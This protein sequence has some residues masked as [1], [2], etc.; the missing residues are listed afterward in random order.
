MDGLQNTERQLR[1]EIEAVRRELF[2]LKGDLSNMARELNQKMVDAE[3]EVDQV[4]QAVDGI[5]G[6]TGIHVSREGRG[7][8]ISGEEGDSMPFAVTRFM[9]DTTLKASIVPGRI[10]LPSRDGS[11]HATLTPVV[12][13]SSAVD[14]WSSDDD[15]AVTDRYL[16]IVSKLDSQATY[17]GKLHKLVC[18]AD[19][20]TGINH[21]IEYL[22]LLADFGAALDSMTQCY[23][24]DIDI[25]RTA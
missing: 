15:I 7:I 3:E 14:G 6:G 9:D 22:K 10:W 8:R 18:R 25:P 13:S 11:G 12:A 17:N 20:T 23:H 5:S 16:C 24:G 21:D 2:S 1:D 4:K 19:W